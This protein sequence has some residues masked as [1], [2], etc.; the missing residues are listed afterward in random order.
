MNLDTVIKRIVGLRSPD[1]VAQIAYEY[2]LILCRR[3]AEATFGPLRFLASRAMR[4]AEAA[5]AF[6]CFRFVGRK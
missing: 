3:A 5:G 4:V 1:V 6:A 2:S